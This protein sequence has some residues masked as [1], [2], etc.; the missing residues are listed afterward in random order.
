MMSVTSSSD[1]SCLLDEGGIVHRLVVDL[2]IVVARDRLVAG[3]LLALRLGVGVLERN[4]FG[5]L[6]LRHHRLG[7]L[8]RRGGGARAAGSGRGRVVT[9][10]ISITV[11]HFGQVIGV[12]L[13]S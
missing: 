4:E 1:S 2:D 6:R 10:A 8:D 13:R 3:D 11:W 9:A 12:L 7:F 5:V